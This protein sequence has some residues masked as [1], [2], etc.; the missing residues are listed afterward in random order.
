L[1]LTRSSAADFGLPKFMKD[2]VAAAVLRPVSRTAMSKLSIS[3]SCALTNGSPS[4]VGT[5]PRLLAAAR[6]LLII[7]TS[8]GAK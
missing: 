5:S 6:S 7:A 2:T 8:A 3:H 1:T 4:S